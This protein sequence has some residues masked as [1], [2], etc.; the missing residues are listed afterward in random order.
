M[1]KNKQPAVKNVAL[2]FSGLVKSLELCYPYI[3]KNLLDHIGSYDIFCYAEDDENTE[4]VKLLNPIKM[5]KVKSSEVSKIIKPEIKFLKKQNYKTCIHPES[6]RFNLQN[7]YQQLYKINQSFNLLEKYMNENNISYKYF[8]RIRFDMLP[9][10]IFKIEDFKLKKKEIIV[11]KKR[12][13]TLKYQV[14]DMFC[15]TE[16]FRTFKSYYSL[17][18]N[19]RK[20]VQE[21]VSIKPTFFQKIYFFFEKNYSDFFFFLFKTLNKK[22]KKFPRQLLGF[23]LLFPKMFYKEFKRK[24]MCC[25]ERVLFYYLKSE[26]KEIIEKKINFVI[27]RNSRDGLLIFG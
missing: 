1:N 7:N 21:N 10:D 15:I 27:V 12:N 22:Q 18:N 4:K 2:C 25:L 17:Y 14:S 11:P 26:K 24:T 19:F 13:E 9:L 23:F 20:I 16:N 5:E 6:F 8:I 3:K